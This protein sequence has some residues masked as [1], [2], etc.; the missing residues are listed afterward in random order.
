MTCL[1]FGINFTLFHVIQPPLHLLDKYNVYTSSH[2]DN[3]I[4]YNIQNKLVS[5]AQ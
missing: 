1:S 3:D 4:E 5:P 2:K